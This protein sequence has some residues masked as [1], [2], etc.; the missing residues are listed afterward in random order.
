MGLWSARSHI[1]LVPRLVPQRGG[2]TVPQFL[3]RPESE[4]PGFIRQPAWP[5]PGQIPG[6]SATPGQ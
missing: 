4:F 2:L 5:A 1:E 6:V 3:I